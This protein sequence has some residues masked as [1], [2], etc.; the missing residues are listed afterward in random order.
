MSELV[1]ISF[2]STLVSPSMDTLH[3]SLLSSKITE[4]F[5]KKRRAGSLAYLTHK[6]LIHPVLLNIILLFMHQILCTYITACCFYY[7]GVEGGL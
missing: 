1:S 3:Y 4:Y 7:V 5:L 6:Y 2:I